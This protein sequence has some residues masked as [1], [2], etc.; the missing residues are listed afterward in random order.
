MH[1]EDEKLDG[2]ALEV[3][4]IPIWYVAVMV[5]VSVSGVI[6]DLLSIGFIVNV[7]GVVIK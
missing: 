1:F 7:V 6:W 2:T 5:L 3:D 4:N